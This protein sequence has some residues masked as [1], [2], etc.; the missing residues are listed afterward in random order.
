MCCQ[1][2]DER[3]E[4]QKS[5]GLYEVEERGGLDLTMMLALGWDR[6]TG[7]G[8]PGSGEGAAKPVDTGV[9]IS[10]AS[11]RAHSVAGS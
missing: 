6:G 3:L 10:E 7:R 2:G 9:S 5:E 4:R 1:H 11:A 8:M